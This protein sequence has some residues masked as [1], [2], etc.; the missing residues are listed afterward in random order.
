MYYDEMMKIIKDK[1]E[2]K[3]VIAE[4]KE[5]HVSEDTIIKIRVFNDYLKKGKKYETK[6]LW[7]D[8]YLISNNIDCFM[9]NRW[10]S[11]GLINA[12]KEGKRWII[13]KPGNIL[14][15]KQRIKKN[16]KEK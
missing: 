9:V 8:G 11:K 7:K 5:K 16:R 10:C 15:K 14:I 3:Q 2:R 4:A 13:E 12:R 1:N 6:D